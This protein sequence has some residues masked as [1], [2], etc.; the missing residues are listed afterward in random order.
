VAH[1]LVARGQ[2]HGLR[3]LLLVGLVSRSEPKQEG[4]RQSYSVL[5]EGEGGGKSERDA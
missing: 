1:R 5:S 4:Y 2:H 3:E